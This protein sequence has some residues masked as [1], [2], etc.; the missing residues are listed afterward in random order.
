MTVTL[1][2][3]DSDFILAVVRERMEELERGHEYVQEEYGKHKERK[4]TSLMEKL[5]TAGLGN[6]IKAEGELYADQSARLT[7]CVELLTVGS[8]NVG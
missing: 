7:K 6:A 8:E 4:D 1:T 5:L 2:Q 3:K